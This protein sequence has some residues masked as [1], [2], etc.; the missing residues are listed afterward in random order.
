MSMSVLL[1]LRSLLRI[2]LLAK[3]KVSNLME[4]E[5]NIPPFSFKLFSPSMVSSI[6]NHV[7]THLNKMVLPSEN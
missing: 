5:V 2:S 6:E 7:H 3:S 1:N 4:E